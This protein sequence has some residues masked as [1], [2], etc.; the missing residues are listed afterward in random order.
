[1]QEVKGI[2]VLDAFKAL[3]DISDDVIQD[4]VKRVSKKSKL[5]ESKDAKVIKLDI[6]GNDMYDKGQAY[7][8]ARTGDHVDYNGSKFEIAQDDSR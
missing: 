8:Y 3:E 6:S 1:M 4:E 2:T 5:K 7:Y